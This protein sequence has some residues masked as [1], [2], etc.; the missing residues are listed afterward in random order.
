[1]NTTRNL[2]ITY[3]QPILTPGE[4]VK[5]NRLFHPTIDSW[6][7]IYKDMLEPFNFYKYTCPRLPIN[8]G[9]FP[10]ELARK[11][12]NVLRIPI[13]YGGSEEVRI[14]SELLPLKE[15]II[16][17]L[18]YD[19]WVTGEQWKEFYCHLTIDNKLVTPGETHRYPGFHGDGLQGGKFKTKLVCEHSYIVTSPEPTIIAMQP[20]F[21]SHFNEDRDNIFK[22]FDLQVKKE[23]RYKLCDKDLYLI[24]PYVVHESP[25][26]V[27]EVFRT[28]VRLTTTPAELLMPKNTVNPM[29]SGQEYPA[30]IEIREFVTGPRNYIPYEYY[31]ITEYNE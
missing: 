14:P 19:Y 27:E 10:I 11:C 26:I 16:R 20:F 23:C 6:S 22:A 3:Q 8:L 30:R 1:M 4:V 31:G 9:K 18:Q 17:I 13:K 25:K 29:F 7:P 2:G 28:F 24:D 5:I 21:V 12:P 15:E